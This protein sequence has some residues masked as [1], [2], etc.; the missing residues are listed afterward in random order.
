VRGLVALLR[1]E[2]RDARGPLATLFVVAAAAPFVL[3][4]FVL[5]R[6]EEELSMTLA[7][8]FVPAAFA[9]FVVAIASDLVAR[10]VA[11]K[12]I[13]GLAVLPVPISRVWTAK[14]LFLVVASAAFLAWITGA[15]FAAVASTASKSAMD[16]LSG[17][18][19]DA[20]PALFAGVALGAA[21]LFFSTLLERGMA[22]VL[23]AFIVLIAGAW[24]VQ[25]AELPAAPGRLTMFAVDVVP[26]IVALAFVAAS[27]QAFVRGPI[28][29]S[30]KL[31]LALV[32]A[33]VLAAVVLPAGSALAF[34]V[35][36][37]TCLAPGDGSP[38]LLRAFLSPDEKWL[39]VEDATRS[40]ASRTWIVGVED[41]ACRPIA[42]GSTRFA[43]WGAWL[44]GSSLHVR[45]S[46]F[47]LVEIP[48]RTRTLEIEPSH[49]GVVEERPMVLEP[50]PPAGDRP[51]TRF[52]DGRR[53]VVVNGVVTIVAADGAPIRRLFPPAKEN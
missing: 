28:H 36:R 44:P 3:R 46:T 31:R 42:D 20:W 43:E 18:L 22:A 47:S 11:T 40:G 30:G 12:R 37:S 6:S 10:D 25:I 16:R 23:S 33:G 45:R 50:R 24:I 9:V 8:M 49:L 15:A 21:T 53:V 4:V 41:G 1:R 38:V 14:V 39:A 32:G 5:E 34:G 52:R 48:C 35:E 13:D 51:A 17:D 26:V 29:S 7:R 27:R 2:T 19:A